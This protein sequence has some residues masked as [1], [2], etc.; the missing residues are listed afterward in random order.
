MLPSDPAATAPAPPAL[1]P[2]AQGRMRRL[3]EPTAEDVPT[4]AEMMLASET[5]VT[6]P[7]RSARGSSM[8]LASKVSVAPFERV[9]EARLSWASA[10]VPFALT[11]MVL[12]PPD[13]VT[14]PTFW[15]R[16]ARRFPWSEV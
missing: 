2:T 4:R 16:G 5:S 12:A 1:L 9:R 10:V 8:L 13:K 11:R 3:G 7:R 15:T 6:S 14:A